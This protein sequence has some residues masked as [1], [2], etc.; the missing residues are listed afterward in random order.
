[1]LTRAC[2]VFLLILEYNPSTV[3][4][5]HI[6]LIIMNQHNLLTHFIKCVCKSIIKNHLGQK[7]KQTVV[8]LI[9][10][11]RLKISPFFTQFKVHVARILNF[12]LIHLIFQAWTWALNVFLAVKLNCLL[13]ISICF[14]ALPPIRGNTS[15][16]EGKDDV[17]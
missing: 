4:A 9:N 2:G 13:K 16:W 14:R 10:W 5:D 17:T 7:S 6:G 12:Y 1:M 15:S 3:F 8:C 11:Y